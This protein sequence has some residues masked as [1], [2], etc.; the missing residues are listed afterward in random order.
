MNNKNNNQKGTTQVVVFKTQFDLP[1]NEKQFAQRKAAENKLVCMAK[2]RGIQLQLQHLASGKCVC[3]NGYVSIS[4]S[5]NYV[6]VA[7]ADVPV[8]IDLQR[9]VKVN[10]QAIAKKFF[11]AGEQ[12]ALRLANCEKTFFEIWCKKEALW[13]SLEIQP[14][15]IATVD[16][17]GTVFTQKTL[18]LS[19]ETFFLA[20]TG[21]ANVCIE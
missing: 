12:Q 6:A 16:T 9:K 3:E 14:P 17:T 1:P 11:T 4:H 7:L 20:V 8:G 5:G 10:F 2:Q 21:N 15:T 19:G 18:T 13:K